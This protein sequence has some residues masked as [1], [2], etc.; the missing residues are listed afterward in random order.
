MISNKSA[1]PSTLAEPWEFA[2]WGRSERI[3]SLPAPKAPPHA[4]HKK[5]G[6]WASTAICGND[7]T[8]SCLYVSALCAAQAGRYAPIALGLVALVLFLF[9]KVYAEVGSALPLN[10]GT[11]T[12]LLNTTNKKLAAA[13][14]CLTLLS[15][16]ATAVIS[17]G[18]AMHYAHNLWLGLPVFWATIGLLG[19]FA[20]LNLVGISESAVV[21]II[22]FAIH[23][24]T[25][26]VL[27]AA[28]IYAM[29]T[30]PS[31]LIANWTA[32]SDVGLFHALVFGFAAAMLGISGFESSANFIE[33]QKPGV[34]PKTLRNMWL[35][36]AIFNPLTSLL[37]LAL[38]P[39]ATIQTVPPDLL[40]QM[41]TLSAGQWLG[42]LVSIDAV[43]VLSGA[44]LTS[45]VG[46]TGLIRRM[47][48]DRCL[49][50]A[51]LS[52]NRLRQT[53]HWIILS[54]FL[55][56]CS[57]MMATGGDVET[58]AG[59][60]TIS[61]LS[62][63]ALFAVGNMLL[64]VKRSRLPRADRASWP[65][66]FIALV[67]VLIGLGGNVLLDPAYVEIFLEYFAAVLAIVGVMFLRVQLLRVVLFVLRSIVDMVTGGSQWLKEVV[68]KS[69][70]EINSAT[71]IYFTKGD[72]PAELNRAALYVLENEQTNLL[73]IVYA[74]DDDHPV[75]DHLSGLLSEI[76][77]LYPSLR[78]DF[79]AVRGTFG[80]E[81]I[82]SL[83]EKLGVPL[84][85]MF[86]GTPGDR[87]PHRI[88]ALGGV[89]L[90]L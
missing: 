57:I 3:E 85:Y 84:N 56:C 46:V 49:P 90:I 67:A 32:P 12:V 42:T 21:A 11:Y 48:L 18:E 51:L 25:L 4:A 61:F 59:V 24:V 66:V 39:L 35:A 72:D 5:L 29:L 77:H 54:F 15:Y 22:I 40:A 1:G 47:S 87:F 13:A 63:M 65:L 36:V 19:F 34:F 62:V 17:A 43:L 55:V 71:V 79:L 82:R 33:E 80:P 23:M 2:G 38:L 53:N 75:P 78:I 16:V 10:G 89:R 9:R 50:Q 28:G 14:A 60:Y 6:V 64:K 26:T 69:I 37:S 88:E 52:E 7:I 31:Q 30:D 68:Y 58:L 81:L 44:V 45:Y 8:S 74:F 76:D 20:F 86:I 73:K 83:S 70:D 27:S 41:G